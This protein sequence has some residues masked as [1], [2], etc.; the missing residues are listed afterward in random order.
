MQEGLI[1]GATYMCRSKG[2]REQCVLKKIDN[3]GVFLEPICGFGWSIIEED[4]LIPFAKYSFLNYYEIK[5]E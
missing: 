1:I 4:G 3:W 2:E 5:Q